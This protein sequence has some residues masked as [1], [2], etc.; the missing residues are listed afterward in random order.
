MTLS[1]GECLLQPDF[2]AA[3]LAGAPMIVASTRPL[4]T[5]YNVPGEFLE[6]VLPHFDTMLHDH[7]LTIQERYA[8]WTEWTT[9][10]P[11]T[12][13]WRTKPTP[14]STSSRGRH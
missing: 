9:R 10:I 2:T 3:L 13:K 1:G 4:E 6:K 12:R 5:A 11:E 14:I 8:K 7:K